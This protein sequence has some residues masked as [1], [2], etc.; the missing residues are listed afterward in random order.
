MAHQVATAKGSKS[1]GVAPTVVYVYAITAVGKK[2]IGAPRFGIDGV[3]GV[4]PIEVGDVVCWVSRVDA[5]EFGEQL[6]ERMENLEWLANAGVRH[7]QVVAALAAQS[8]VV[9]A[10]FGTVFSTEAAL[11]ADV[12]R[13]R[14]GIA[15]MLKRVAD[16]DEWGV[17]VFGEPPKP[18]TEAT[19]GASSGRDYLKR[20][21]A[22]L[23]RRGE[24]KVDA[25][26]MHLVSALKKTASD[27]AAVG[28][29]SGGQRNLLWQGAFLVKR[30]AH[31]KF[32]RVLKQFASKWKGEKTIECTGP[33]PPYSFVS[34]DGR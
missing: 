11:L 5:L 13:R 1:A 12:K 25:E 7:Q 2:A 22:V 23:E 3:A 8:A 6:Q 29:V 20:K 10:R 34:R 26:L 21:A 17:K 24:Q 33:W 19:V 28:K 30:K 9:P 15:A 16:S 27:M 14:R 18:V 4:V 31:G 32:N